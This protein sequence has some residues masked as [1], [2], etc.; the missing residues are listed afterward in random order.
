M[1][2]TTW[3]QVVGAVLLRRKTSEGIMKYAI[4]AAILVAL[5]L[6]P[7]AF[8]QEEDEDDAFNGD[9]N[10]QLVS[11]R[12]H[13]ENTGWG[14]YRIDNTK[15]SLRST[16]GEYTLSFSYPSEDFGWV[17]ITIVPKAA[18][19][20]SSENWNFSD[21]SQ[22]F[23][24]TIVRLNSKPRWKIKYSRQNMERILL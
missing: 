2:R 11:S 9:E 13:L 12:E 14:V 18:V 24:T 6:S 7:S 22:F 20:I 21:V 4:T 8:A 5:L 15:C 19:T 17:G 23:L 1:R 10:F 3:R 16:Q